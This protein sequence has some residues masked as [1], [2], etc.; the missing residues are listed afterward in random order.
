M[1]RQFVLDK[2]T[3][4]LIEE[5]ASN[6]AGNRSMVVRTAVQLLAEMEDRLDKIEADPA[7]QK[8]MAESDKAIREGRV[9]PHSEVVRMSRAH[10]KR[11]K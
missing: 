7:F 9:T 3:D 10:S 5:L 8:M 11:R 2:R 4:K 6:G 1:R